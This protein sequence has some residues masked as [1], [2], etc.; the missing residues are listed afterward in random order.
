MNKCSRRAGAL[1]VSVLLMLL[2]CS[3]SA[4]AYP[5]KPT[6]TQ[7]SDCMGWLESQQKADGSI[8]G[9]AFSDWVI[10]AIAAAG[11]DPHTVRTSPS[12]PSIV[13]FIKTKE[14]DLSSATDYERHVMAICAAGENP[15]DFGGHNY[16]HDL[17]GYYNNGQ[18]GSTSQLNDDTYGIMALVVAG[19]EPSS[20]MVQSTASFIK[21]NQNSDGGW[22]WGVGFPSD[23]DSTAAA[24]MALITANESPTNASITSGLGYIKS[25]Q[26]DDGGFCSDATHPQSNANSDAYGIMA[27]RASGGDPRGAAWT[28]SNNTPVEHLL[29][30]QLANGGFKDTSGDTDANVCAVR[31]ALIAITGKFHPQHGYKNQLRIEGRNETLF[32]DELFYTAPY[33][34]VADSSGNRSMLKGRYA[35]VQLESFEDITGRAVYT[36]DSKGGYTVEVIDGEANSASDWWMYAV[37]C[38]RCSVGADNRLL[39]EDDRVLWYYGAFTS[40]VSSLDVPALVEVNTT[41]LAHASYYNTSSGSWMPL[42]G[43]YVWCEDEP[44]TPS[45][46]GA[47][48]VE[49]AFNSTGVYSVWC[50]GNRTAKY[51]AGNCKEVIRSERKEIKVVKSIPTPLPTTRHTLNNALSPTHFNGSGSY[52]L[53]DTITS[54]VWSFGDGAQASGAVVSHTYQSYRWNGTVYQ[55]FNA[56]LTVSDDEGASNTTHLPV[57]VFMAG[58]ANGDG[59]ANILDAALVGLHWDAA[60]GSAGYHDGADLN[61]DDVVNVLDAAIVGLN[62]NVRAGGV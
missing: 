23:V 6:D 3:C 5:Y 2:I 33:I 39:T 27:I 21:S 59:V 11:T 34:A 35:A 14:G 47:G 38:V 25:M 18:M 51:P 7:V 9:S 44:M 57:L 22:S 45:T 1:V 13:D 56:S 43:A 41:F 46:D 16:T 36:N 10:I 4:S 15:E 20:T 60:Y 19:V 28:K 48:G 53:N 8:G 12:S 42:E 62:W 31:D 52:D 30:L 32:D 29:S 24:I 49:M 50:A 37:N 55:H 54:Y 17:L 26:N 61:N 40:R 58:D